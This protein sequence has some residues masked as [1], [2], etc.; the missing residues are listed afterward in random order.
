MPDVPLNFIL[1]SCLDTPGLASTSVA[2]I[3]PSGAK[4]VLGVLYIPLKSIGIP[5]VVV[6]IAILVLASSIKNPLLSP[7]TGS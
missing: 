7:V 6:P 3:V 1:T 5:K 4:R 2:D